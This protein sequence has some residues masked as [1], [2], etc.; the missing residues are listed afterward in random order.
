MAVD[1]SQAILRKEKKSPY[2]SKFILI[3]LVEI[4]TRVVLKQD[5][6]TTWRLISATDFS[7]GTFRNVGISHR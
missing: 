1:M 6:C 2:K 4:L 7:A 5:V 3:F